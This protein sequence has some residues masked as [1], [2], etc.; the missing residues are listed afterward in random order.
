MVT[1][2]SLFLWLMTDVHPVKVAVEPGVA[3]VEIFLDGESVGVAT[4]P[5]WETDCDFG[6]RLR[7]H[8]LVAVAKGTSGE[9]KGRAVQFVNS[10]RARAEVD[11]VFEGG[12]P[13]APTLLRVITESGERLKPLAV[14]VTFDGFMLQQGSD[15]RFELPTFDP[16][17]THLVSAEGF[18]PEGATARRDVI[19]SSTFGGQVATELTAISVTVDKRRKLLARELEGLL[20]AGDEVLTVAAVDRRGGRV[21]MVRDHGAWPALRRTGR[22]IDNRDVTSRRVYMKELVRRA[23]GNAWVE[24]ISPENDRFYLLVPNPTESRGIKLFP[25]LQPFNLENWGMPWLSTHIVSSKATARGQRLSEAVALAGVRAA[26]GGCP[27][28]VVLVLGD[29]AVDESWHR[30]PTVRE[31]LRAL[32]V[33][34]VVWSPERDLSSSS[35]G[36][37]ETATGIGGLNQASRRLLKNLR[38]QWIVWVEGRYL[39]HEIELAENDKGIRLAE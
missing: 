16:R 15:G 3:S 38:R 30:P 10:P 33:P 39:P 6:Q 14:F 25:V 36:K 32:R 18:F 34:L 21:Y 2:L 17:Q 9:E 22:V 23:E 26:A 37:A 28:V 20:R 12:T 4:A 31:Y 7:P 1:F 24:E 11:L 8:R 19:F 29:N 13:E 35:W 5:N 27:R